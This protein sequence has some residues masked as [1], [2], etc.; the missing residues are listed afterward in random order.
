ML[1]LDILKETI[2]VYRKSGGEYVNGRWVEGVA[3]VS[4]HKNTSVQPVSA[5]DLLMIPEGESLEGVIR[6]FDV[7][8]LYA[9]D[10]DAG[11]EADIIEYYDKKYKV[12]R[13]D[14]WRNGFMDHYEALAVLER[15]NTGV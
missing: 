13:V 8:P 7:L 6:V 9:Q 3:D 12:V 11:K 10:V 15:Q 4:E 1:P 5:S 2:T 14:P